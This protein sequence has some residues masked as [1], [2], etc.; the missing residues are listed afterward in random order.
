MVL[1]SS[2]IV[3]IIL[4]EPGFDAL[5]DKLENAEFVFVGAPTLL[6][7]AIVL[8]ARIPRAAQL[9][10]AGFVRRSGAEILP[11]TEDHVAAALAAFLKFGKGRHRAALNFGDCMSYACASIA[12]MPLLY[13]GEDFARTD[14]GAA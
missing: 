14:I 5:L 10:L 4:K 6:E 13:A 2:A 8:H 3:A 12:Q 7:T 11:F 1:D 9:S